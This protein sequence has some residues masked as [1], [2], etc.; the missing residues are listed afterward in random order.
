MK[1]LY[2]LL[3]VSSNAS[4]E[5]IKSAYRSLAKKYHPDRNGN[6]TSESFLQIKTAYDTLIDPEKRAEYDRKLFLYGKS[7]EK[8]EHSSQSTIETIKR[9]DGVDSWCTLDEHIRRNGKELF[10]CNLAGISFADCNLNGAVLESADLI[11]TRFKKVL[12]VNSNLKNAKIENA[13]FNDVDFKMSNFS[14]ISCKK[15]DFNGCDFS[16]V[17]FDLSDFELCR[18]ENCKFSSSH[19]INSKFISCDMRDLSFFDIV[20]DVV[21][22]SESLLNKSE[23]IYEETYNTIE[24]KKIVFE[25]TDLTNT[26]FAK[27]KGEYYLGGVKFVDSDFSNAILVDTILV[28]SKFINCRF[29][30]ANLSKADFR[31]C[32]ILKDSKIVNSNLMNADFSSSRIIGVD[33]TT[34]SLVN[35]YFK[36]SVLTNVKFPAGF[37]INK[38]VKFVKTEKES[39]V[40]SEA[41][42]LSLVVLALIV[43]IIIIISLGFS[44]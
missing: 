21:D 36:D 44:K 4:I 18:F 6:I 19:I 37:I 15:T 7:Y 23:F 40:D 1:N 12:L 42:G 30:N 13:V 29:D 5:V 8:E 10:N 28:N 3:E 9:N 35:A 14:E 41:I 26:K 22:F 31:N 43:F 2:E 11:K 20:L 38:S 16:N 34:N 24:H 25:K 32:S 33:F 39:P 17:T 27:R